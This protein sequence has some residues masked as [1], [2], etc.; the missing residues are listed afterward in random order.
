MR[1]L[2]FYMAVVLID[3]LM[4]SSAV[5]A[6]DA[7]SISLSYR[8]FQMD[9]EPGPANDSGLP[10][11]MPKKRVNKTEHTVESIAVRKLQDIVFKEFGEPQDGYIELSDAEYIVFV[12]NTGRVGLGLYLVDLATNT[13]SQDP[14]AHGDIEIKA[15]LKDKAGNE[16]LLLHHVYPMH[17]GHAGE[18]YSLLSAK[19][20]SRGKA[21]VN[22]TSLGEAEYDSEE[23]GDECA[24]N[25][26][27]GRVINT[28]VTASIADLNNDS[29]PDITVTS[30]QFDCGI[31]KAAT[32]TTNYYAGPHGF[33]FTDV[34]PTLKLLDAQK[35]ALKIFSKNKNASAA[36]KTLEQA[37]I[38]QVRYEKPAGMTTSAYV[39]LLND[40]AFFIGPYGQARQAISILDRVIQMSPNRA[41]AYLNRAEVL[42]QML[43]LGELKTQEEK[44]GAAKE[45][46]KD[47]EAYKTLTNKSSIDQWEHFAAFN[48]SSYPKNIDVCEYIKKYYETGRSNSG[49]WRMEEIYLET[50]RLDINN[51]GYI[52]DVEFEPGKVG[53]KTYGALTYKDAGNNQ[54]KFT[55]SVSRKPDT[56]YG[57]KIFAFEG[58]I[59]KLLPLN[60]VSY[61]NHDKEK[62]IC[63][64]EL[65]EKRADDG[66]IFKE[67]KA[68]HQVGET[69]SASK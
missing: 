31:K 34:D 14:I 27:A 17:A 4:F 10:K 40:Y 56:G 67:L 46:M 36:S 55:A 6:K 12:S 65:E 37:G 49:M 28:G 9:N 54:I 52:E 5:W 24:G 25:I 13:I 66:H 45:I 48:L 51:D 30:K 43:L 7:D 47:Y 2:Y 69:G 11:K 18:S 41:V 23:S 60:D 16:F 8:E 22:L 39:G 38:N 58:K 32:I 15:T 64:S 63:E 62:L 33:V 21:I 61:I 57:Y 35:Q 50:R 44:I 59:Y 53:Y 19:K 68:I 1:R 26:N 3:Q 20:S 29:Y 42:Y